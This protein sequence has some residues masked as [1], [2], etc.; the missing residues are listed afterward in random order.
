MP[1]QAVTIAGRNIEELRPYAALVR[2]ELNVKEVRFAEQVDDFAI[3]ILQVNAKA[4][5]PR[6]GGKMQEVIKASKSGAWKAL[7]DGRVELAGITLE[8][9][10]FTLGLKPKEGVSAQALPSNDAIVVLDTVLTKEL[11]E[12][13]IARD[14]VRMVQQARREAGLHVSDQ[15]QLA[16]AANDSIRAAL[17]KHQSYIAEQ[18]LAHAI[19]YGTA[20][21]GMFSQTGP[22][23]GCDVTVSLQKR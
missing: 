23:A 12:E 3:F 8:K 11:E 5:G 10:E 13:G 1:L 14:V 6:L 18:T 21:T 9:H 22:V 16:I 19:S 15:I 17:A 2:D 20:E 4:A 7:S